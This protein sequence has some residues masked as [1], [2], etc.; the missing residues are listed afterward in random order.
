V[1]PAQGI[2]MGIVQGLTEFLPVSSSGHLA[3]ARELLGAGSAEDVGFEVAVHA[4][5]LLA[6]LI[7]FRTKIITILSECLSGR[8]DGW[9][10]IFYLVIG[11]IPAGV[12]GL[13]IRHQVSMLFNNIALVGAAWLFTACLLF[14]S[15]KYAGERV[16]VVEMGMWRSLFIGMGQAIALIPGVSRSGSTLGVGLLAGVKREAALEFA[17]ILSLPSVGGATLLTIPEWLDGRTGFSMVHVIGGT[18]AFISG[19]IAIAW[20]LRIVSNGKLIWFAAYCALLGTFAL[21]M[22]CF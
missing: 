15:E 22:S 12:V 4:G 10:W 5:T 7:F 18:A 21:A 11:T 6:V 20:M 9:R 8:G 2:L 19:Y 1:T 17:F 14:I 13:L 16:T 3:L